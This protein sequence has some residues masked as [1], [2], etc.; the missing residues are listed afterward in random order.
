MWAYYL[1]IMQI[2]I[3]DKFVKFHFEGA[4]APPFLL[5]WWLAGRPSLKA[6]LS[7]WYNLALQIWLLRLGEQVTEHAECQ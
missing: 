3:L 1:K 7:T 6:R 2:P 4:G 5:Q